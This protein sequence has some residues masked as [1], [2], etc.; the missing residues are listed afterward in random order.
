MLIETKRPSGLPILSEVHRSNT[1]DSEKS[2]GCSRAHIEPVMVE[3]QNGVCFI[4]SKV[5]ANRWP[6][7]TLSA[8][9]TSG[10]V[11]IFC[12][13]EASA[14]LKS[15]SP[16][17][18]KI[19]ERILSAGVCRGL[20]ES[21]IG[22]SNFRISLRLEHRVSQNVTPERACN[23]TLASHRN[24]ALEYDKSTFG[25]TPSLQDRTRATDSPTHHASKRPR[26]GLH[27]S[28][29]CAS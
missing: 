24:G 29:T 20:L 2:R 1:S 11:Y 16:T 3:I 5:Q 26:H 25:Y 14:R 4:A 13:A 12:C 17:R 19:G 7:I 9:R 15:D 23:C 8:L 18:V 21:I 22:F 27:S 6:I 10:P 28:W